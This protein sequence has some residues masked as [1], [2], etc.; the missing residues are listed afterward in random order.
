MPTAKAIFTIQQGTPVTVSTAVSFLGLGSEGD[1]DALR[2]LTHPTLTLPPV[3]YWGNPHRDIGFDNEILTNARTN[4]V[5]TADGGKVIRH[6][7]GI[8]AMLIEEIW[9]GNDRQASMP[10]YFL[11]QLIE[12]WQNPPGL[13][14][15]PG[16]YITWQ[17]RDR[18]PGR[19]FN[20]TLFGLK[21]GAETL[22]YDFKDVR[23]RGGYFK[24]GDSGNA[25]D[26]L[27]ALETGLVDRDVRLAMHVVSEVP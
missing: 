23:A 3:T 20:V 4:F 2:I 11:R 6:E 18:M 25:L 24:G 9:K 27:N 12:Y 19:T 26:A 10:S 5:E 16:Q 22:G 21:V 1:P 13:T 8:T 17:P 7:R 15:S 14:G